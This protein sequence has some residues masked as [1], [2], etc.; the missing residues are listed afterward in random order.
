MSKVQE[1]RSMVMTLSASERTSLAHELIL[2]LDDPMDAQLTA[3]QEVEIQRRLAVV[4]EG[5]ASG[6]PANEVFADV[7]K[8]YV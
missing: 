5:N 8:K 7:R 1:A 6:R 4:R 2:S 3:S